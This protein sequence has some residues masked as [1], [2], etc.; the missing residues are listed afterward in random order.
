M[1]I[2]NYKPAERPFLEEDQF[3]WNSTLVTA[4]NCVVVENN[5]SLYISL[6]I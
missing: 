6:Q 3:N 2:W 4:F 1:E 5:L